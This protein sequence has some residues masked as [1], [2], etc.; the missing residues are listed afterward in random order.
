MKWFIHP[1]TTLSTS[2]KSEKGKALQQMAMLFDNHILTGPS[3][4]CIRSLTDAIA[5]AAAKLDA[6]YPRSRKTSVNCNCDGHSG[7]ISASPE[8][9]AFETPDYFRISFNK[10]ED[11]LT[12]SEAL[13]IVKGG[14]A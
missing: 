12:L 10:V 8:G 9:G 1:V 6:E 5:E 13:N 4:L 2:G 11:I 3:P 7:Q 14:E